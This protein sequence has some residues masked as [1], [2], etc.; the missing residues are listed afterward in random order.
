MHQ[1]ILFE[2]VRKGCLLMV[3]S[4]TEVRLL[5]SF[6]RSSTSSSTVSSLHSS[7]L[8]SS[9]QIGS[10]AF[11]L[12]RTLHDRQ[13][14]RTGVAKIRRLVGEEEP[15]E[16]EEGQEGPKYARGMLKVELSDGFRTVKVS[17]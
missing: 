3:V 6:H 11:T 10:S 5:D 15:D 12:Q 9:L 16:D 2:G 4:I 13:E 7:R 14:A 1:K 17:S 8:V